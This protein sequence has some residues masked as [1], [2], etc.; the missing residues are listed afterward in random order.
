MLGTGSLHAGYASQPHVPSPALLT[1]L[2]FPSEFIVRGLPKE[3]EQREIG[4]KQQVYNKN[5]YVKL[6]LEYVINFSG[7]V[8]K[9]SVETL[10]SP[11]HKGIPLPM[12][13]LS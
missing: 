9:G 8:Q 11:Y 13:P 6:G 10:A 3:F 7:R 4:M 1:T 2:Q 5:S 12:I